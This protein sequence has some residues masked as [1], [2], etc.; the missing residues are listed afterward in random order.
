MIDKDVVLIADKT[1]DFSNINLESK[2]LECIP[3]QYFNEIY[4]GLDS[5]SKKVIHYNSPADF[6]NNIQKHKN[7]IV[8]SIWSGIGTKFRKALIPSICEANQICYVGADPYVHFLCQDKYLT[9]KF[10]S[11]YHLKSPKGIIY[12]ENNDKEKIK[13]LALPLVVKPNFE[14]GSNGISQHNL[15]DSYEDAIHLANR[16]LNLYDESILIEE[17]IA[18][19]E[20]CISIIG[21]NHK[22]DMIDASQLIINGNHFF[23]STLYG[24]EAKIME[25]SN[26]HLQQGSK[27]L[28]P[29][30]KQIFKKIYFD[31]GKVELLRIDGRIDAQ[32]NFNLIELTPDAYLGKRGSTTF[33][34]KN[35]GIIYEKML[36]ML[37]KNAYCDYIERWNL[38]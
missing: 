32:G 36:E 28:S 16:L 22:I 2:N 18:G 21:D 14:G 19:K 5:V 6:C 7:D 30:W 15:V 37:L 23:E 3:P 13:T 4:T 9:K 20:I 10:C 29:K 1:E 25:V 24:Y 33:C 8:L 26:R 27:F 11:L 31:L 35:N 34:A 17:Y 12:H 38:N